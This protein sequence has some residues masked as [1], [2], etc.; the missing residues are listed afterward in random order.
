MFGVGLALAGVA[1]IYWPAA[2]NLAGAAVFGLRWILDHD[3]FVA[4]DDEGEG[5]TWVSE[6]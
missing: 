2:L 5:G 1:F 4:V 6:P 3:S